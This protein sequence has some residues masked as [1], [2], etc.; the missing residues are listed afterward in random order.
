MPDIINREEFI[1]HKTIKIYSIKSNCTYSEFHIPKNTYMWKL[2]FT[3]YKLI[4]TIIMSELQKPEQNTLYNFKILR[5]P[6]FGLV[7]KMSTLH[8]RVPGCE[9]QLGILTPASC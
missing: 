2:K 6:M 4:V 1:K 8:T 5:W 3:W 9:S 7:V